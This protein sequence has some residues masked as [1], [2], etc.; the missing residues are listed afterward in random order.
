MNKQQITHI[1]G[2]FFRRLKKYGNNAAENFNA[3]SIH[4]FR[5]EYKKLRAF[6]R[7]ISQESNRKIK[8]SK[9]L[10]HSYSVAGAIRDLQLQQQ[11][12]AETSKQKS[13][14]SKPVDAILQK[15]INTLEA[16]LL[17]ILSKNPIA[18]CKK[19]ITPLLPDKY[20]LGHFKLFIQ[21][22]LASINALLS[23]SHISDA[24][25]HFIRKS[26]KDL[27]YNV[28]LYKGTEQKKLSQ[29]IYKARNKNAFTQLL[30][31]LGSFQDKCIA[32]ALLKKHR[33]V[34]T[35]T[36]NKIKTQWTKEKNA[37]KH[38]LIEKLKAIIVTQQTALK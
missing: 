30:T 5:V 23:K 7:M 35:N 26:L 37:M 8:I 28:Q 14:N 3:E 16:E 24:N 15:K 12:L 18:I 2:A 25:I 6:L 4:R 32:I 21:N 29:L 17:K 10:K 1:A 31:E 11:R 34:Q 33:P 27:F 13:K 36:Y 19:K 38:L 20:S 9:T 22:K